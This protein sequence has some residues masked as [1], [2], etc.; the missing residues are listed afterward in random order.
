MVTDT[1]KSSIWKYS[2]K[3]IFKLIKL[4]SSSNPFVQK[5]SVKLLHLGYIGK[6]ETGRLFL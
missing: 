1:S 6:M 2:K 4:K 3:E 5:I